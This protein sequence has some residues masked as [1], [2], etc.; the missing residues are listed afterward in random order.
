MLAHST[1]KVTRWDESPSPVGASACPWSKT[2]IEFAL[3]GQL[4]GTA[5]V[6]YLMHYHHF[7]PQAP[8]ESHAHYVGLIRFEGTLEGKQGAFTLC[9]QGTFFQGSAESKFEI[10]KDSGTGELQGIRGAGQ[11]HSTPKASRLTLDYNL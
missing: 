6:E 11:Y 9:D 2:S 4:E 10:L 3:S 1:F 5:W 7:N 8:L